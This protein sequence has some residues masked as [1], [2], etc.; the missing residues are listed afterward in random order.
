M[1][2]SR[3]I[4]VPY[5]ERPVKP[6]SFEKAYS[7]GPSRLYV[8]NFKEI[9]K[10]SA[11]SSKSFAVRKWKEK[12]NFH[13][14]W[15]T[16]IIILFRSQRADRVIKIERSTVRS[17]CPYKGTLHSIV[18]IKLFG[19]QPY[20]HSWIILVFWSNEVRFPEKKGKVKN[21]TVMNPGIFAV[22]VDT[23]FCVWITWTCSRWCPSQIRWR[24]VQRMRIKTG[25][26]LELSQTTVVSKCNK[27]DIKVI[28]IWNSK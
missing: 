18:V 26:D 7:S 21:Y 25:R 13:F 20:I 28:K 3:S 4:I 1:T 5:C 23:M 2:S 6:R 8:R 22:K 24:E 11:P 27:R 12:H 14:F 17:K 15:K 19:L 9:V 16:L 10:S